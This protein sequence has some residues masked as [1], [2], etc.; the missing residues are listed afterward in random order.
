MTRTLASWLP[1]LLLL[2]SCSSPPKPPTVD[3]SRKR[4]ANA[5]VAVELQ[6]CR[7][8]LA[9]TRIVAAEDARIAQASHVLTARIAELQALVASHAAA[10][11]APQRNLLTAVHFD[12]G[13]TR[14]SLPGDDKA[15]IVD[16]AREAPLIVLRGRT[17]G[18]V[19]SAVEGAIAR[20][21]TAVVEQWLVEAG[22]E[23]ARIRST[24]QATGDHAADNSLPGGRALNRRVEIEIY[25]AAPVVASAGELPGPDTVAAAER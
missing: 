14:W 11:A 9:N 18:A 3:E 12:F 15:R 23:R 6:S 4:P 25:R 1:W 8:E 24:W 5:A 2:G 19:D 17:D 10:A 20:Q 22:V 16:A 21:R 13:S 7:S